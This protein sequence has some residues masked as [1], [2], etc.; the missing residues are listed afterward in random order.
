VRIVYYNPLVNEPLGCG[1]HGRGLVAGWRELGH[2]VLV[3]P[4][5]RSADGEPISRVGRFARYPELLKVPARD[6][7]ARLRR[8][9]RGHDVLKSIRAFQP[10]VLVI[11][12]H[13][14]DYVADMLVSEHP[15]VIVGEVNAVAHVEAREHWGEWTLP[16]ERARERAFLASCDRI[17]GVTADV[18][19]QVRGVGVVPR[20]SVVAHN[21]VDI[22]VFSPAIEPDCATA[23]WAASYHH[24]V[25]YAGKG[26]G[27][28]D[29]ACM[30][31]AAKR[32]SAGLESVGYLFV[33]P[34][35]EEVDFGSLGEHCLCTGMTPHSAVG[36]HLIC[37]DVLWSA[38]SNTYGSPLKMYEYLAMGRPFVFAMDGAA[39]ADARET[40][41]GIVVGRGDDPALAHAVIS[42]LREP[43]QAASLGR[44]GRKWVEAHGSWHR[45]AETMVS[46]LDVSGGRE[47]ISTG[48]GGGR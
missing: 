7:R 36:R 42:L 18:I 39:V 22:A 17:C 9:N 31:R 21:G 12:R 20:D 1:I 25:G 8:A 35:A 24:V 40:S 30:A 46:G 11:R 3:I 43:D 44:G 28:H 38:F 2:D 16:W 4:E 15:A 19:E 26:S 32:I 48:S 41:G 33:G 34:D 37:A 5:I 13:A 6:I 27:L 45:S 29:L 23:A 10:D 14:Y 47:E